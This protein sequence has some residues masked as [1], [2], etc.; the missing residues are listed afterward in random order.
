MAISKIKGNYY[1]LKP[2]ISQFKK[3]L[4]KRLIIYGKITKER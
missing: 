3:V 1:D 2:I 4:N